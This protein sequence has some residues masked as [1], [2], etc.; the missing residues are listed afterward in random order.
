MDSRYYDGM[1]VVKWL[2]TKSV[3]MISTIDN[4][5]LTNTVNVKR[6]K[7]GHEGKVDVIVPATVQRYNK[8]TKGTNL[9]DQKPAVYAFD[10]KTPGKYYCRPFG[11]YVDRG[12]T[13]SFIVY[14]KIVSKFLGGSKEKFAKTQKYLG[15]MVAIE[16]IGDFSLTKKHLSTP[17]NA[18]VNLDTEL[19]MLKSTEDVQDVFG[20]RRKT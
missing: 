14:E 12:L 15:R 4:G 3:M 5:H 1:S 20:K 13:N 11:Y 17:D 8:Y 7:K 16:L 6:Q 9:L 18:A 10:R 19:N 2:N